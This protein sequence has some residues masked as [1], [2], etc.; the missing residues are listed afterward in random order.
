MEKLREKLHITRENQGFFLAAALFLAFV[1]FTLLVKVVD[2]KAIGPEGS[3]VGWAALNG[4]VAAKIGLRMGW[5]YVAKVLGILTFVVVAFYAFVGIRQL[6]G[7]RSLKAVDRNIY[8]MGLFYVVVFG[9]YIL[10]DHVALNYRPVILDAVEGLEPS[11]PSSHTLLALCVMGTGV[12]LSEKYL[13][14]EPEW[15]GITNL[16]ML[17]IAF[18]TV[19]GRMLSG[20][21]WLTDIL[22]SV[23]LSA[24]LLVLMYNLFELP[25]ELS[26]ADLLKNREKKEAKPRRSRKQPTGEGEEELADADLMDDEDEDMKIFA[27]SHGSPAAAA[28]EEMEELPEK[29]P[30]AEEPGELPEM[31]L[32]EELPQLPV[33]PVE[34]TPAA[35]VEEVAE[36]KAP[37]EPRPLTAADS[38]FELFGARSEAAKIREVDLESIAA[39]EPPVQEAKND[40]APNDTENSL[41]ELENELGLTVERPVR[42]YPD[43]AELMY[44]FSAEDMED[45]E[46]AA[47]PVFQPALPENEAE[48][49]KQ[50]EPFDLEEEEAP[51]QVRSQKPARKPLFSVK[52]PAPAKGR[53]EK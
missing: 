22:G 39:A 48:E 44:S 18:F 26:L 45:Y 27:A 21:H 7:G 13:P 20:V 28:D 36:E 4:A 30:D 25:E 46:P 19:L 16:G 53:H 17:A 15:I 14:L 29:L 43:A 52:R 8:F 10:F 5:Y 2:V 3:K 11:Y 42:K 6:I 38:L 49:E 33:E 9:L 31:T 1:V 35:V 41:H 40:P 12:M 37:A 34:E 50:A 47:A 51:K 23:L 24:S 32:P